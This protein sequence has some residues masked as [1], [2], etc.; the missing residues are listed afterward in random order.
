MASDLSSQL[1]GQ[2]VEMDKLKRLNEE[3]YRKLEALVSVYVH[4]HVHGFYC[5]L[6]VLYCMV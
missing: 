1:E 6:R 3:L 5:A 2:K 4:V